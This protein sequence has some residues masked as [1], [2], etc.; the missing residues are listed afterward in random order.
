MINIHTHAH[1]HFCCDSDGADVN[2]ANSWIEDGW[3]AGIFYWSQLADEDDVE[4]AEV[5][6]YT[7]GNPP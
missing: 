1:T 2:V 5:K 6:I 4:N 3:N 7:T